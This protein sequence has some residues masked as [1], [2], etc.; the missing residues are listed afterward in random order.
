[1]GIDRPGFPPAGIVMKFESVLKK[2]VNEYRDKGKLPPLLEGKLPGKLIPHLP[3]WL[4]FVDKETG[5]TLRGKLDEVLVLDDGTHAPLDHKSA[6]KVHEK[7]YESYQRQLDAYA[8]LLRE[9]GYQIADVGFLAY[10]IP[11]EGELHKGLPIDVHVEKLKTYP[12][13]IFLLLRKARA[14]LQ[15][16]MRKPAKDCGYCKYVEVR[17]E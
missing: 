7:V 5:I 3:M 10:Y 9:S 8:L 15:G 13:S 2:Y 11:A 4:S 16:P 12:D 14:V 17:K 1:M 6:G